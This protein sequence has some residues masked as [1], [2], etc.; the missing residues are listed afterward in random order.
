MWGVHLWLPK[1]HVEAPV[2]GSMILAGILLKLGGYGLIKVFS[3]CLQSW[4][5]VFSFLM[6]INLWGAVVVALVCLV[7]VDMKSLIAYSS[8]IHMG[9]MVVG[10]FSGSVL[11]YLGRIFMMIAHG[12]SSPAIFSL[13]NFNYEVTGTRRICLQKG[14][15]MLH[16]LRG[17]F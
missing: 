5:E 17:L 8:I 9:V 4:C 1:A 7:S 16:P 11:G 13:A 2:S 14:V 10:I 3:L 12:F 6:S 15:G